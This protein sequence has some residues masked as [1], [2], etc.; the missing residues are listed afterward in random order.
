MARAR[1]QGM[2]VAGHVPADV[3]PRDAA[4]AGMRTMEHMRAELGG[5]CTRARQ[6]VCD[7]IIPVL[8]EHGVWQTPTLLP[9]WVRAHMDSV[10]LADPRLA[11][12][13]YVVRDYWMAEHAQTLRR[14][15][16]A[17]W[18]RLRAEHE[19]ERWLALHLHRAGLSLL[20]GSDAGTSFSH[21]GSGLHDELEMLVDA[22][23][24]PLEALQAATRNAA[25]ALAADSLGTLEV[26][27]M[28]DVVL[29]A[30]DPLADIRNTRRVVAV[31]IGGA[32]STA[33][34]STRCRWRPEPRGSVRP[35]WLFPIPYSLFPVPSKRPIPN[36]A[37]S[38]A[39][40]PPDSRAP[41]RSP[42][43]GASR[44]PLRKWPAA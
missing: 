13:P 6:A 3:D 12:L 16:A 32:S 28:A 10:E 17:D 2:P 29:L 30:A 34:R 11:A 4:R 33:P 14:R 38:S 39:H 25:R 36:P 40:A 8:R 27:K 9:R 44:M 41:T 20:A 26:G 42:V 15:T 18:P 5:Y 43:R 1:E 19:E 7:S 37:T 22:G 21:P 35:C 24:T 31:V 23:L